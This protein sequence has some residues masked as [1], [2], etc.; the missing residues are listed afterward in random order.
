MKKKVLIVVNNMNMGGLENFLMNVV[1]NINLEKFEISFLYCEVIDTYFDNEIKSLGFKITKISSRSSGFFK[2]LRELKRFFEN[3][4]F[5]VVH[6]NYGTSLCFTAARA[7]KKA[8]IK[9]VIVHSHNS[10]AKKVLLHK[11]CKPLISIYANRYLACSKEAADWMFTKRINNSNRVVII[12]NAI[13]TLKY[14]FDCISRS[15]IRKEYGI[16]N[17][18]TVIGHIGRFNAQKNH[19][20]LIQIFYEYKKNNNNSVL[21]LLGDGELKENI[22]TKV[23][24]LNIEN[25]V[26]FGGIRSDIPKVLSAM[27]C[28]VMPS[29]FEGLPVTLVEAQ[30]SGLKCLV[31]DCITNEVNVTDI[32]E[33]YSLNNTAKKWAEKISLS[34][35]A[36]ENYNEIVKSSGF[37]INS[38]LKIIE[39]IYCE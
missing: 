25:H 36:R 16:D 13:D 28:F 1:R 18:K 24:N 15:E 10:K 11:I 17:N 3:N 4:K 30:A 23:R 27:D 20:F 12:K 26:I 29:N 37:D 32:I 39:K 7:A 19:D 31:S 14:K 5:D 35:N 22:K 8:G 33:Y 38:E 6:I 21:L 2:H 34:E 9:N